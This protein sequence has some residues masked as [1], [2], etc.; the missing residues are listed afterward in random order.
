MLQQ[1]SRHRVFAA[2]L[3]SLGWLGASV[4]MFAL[5]AKR[6]AANVV[7]IA[8]VI[9]GV[10]FVYAGAWWLARR[11]RPQWTAS[12]A[13]ETA[14]PAKLARPWGLLLT[15]LVGVYAF[16]VTKHFSM[17]GYVPIVE[18]LSGTSEFDVS[19]VRQGGYFD[20]PGF[21]RYASDYSAKALGPA[22]L[23]VTYYFRSRLFWVVL[24]IGVF[25]ST[26]LFARILPIMLLAPLLLLM[27][28][29][30]R[31]LPA[32]AVVGLLCFQLAFATAVASP[33][34][35]EALKLPE[36]GDSANQIGETAPYVSP[37]SIKIPEHLKPPLKRPD[38]DWRRTSIVYSL[39]DRMLLVP[40]QVIDQWFQFY[41]EPEQRERG[42]GYRVVAPV[43][44]CTYVPI[45]SKLYAVFY[46][47]NVAQGMRGS[48]NAASFMTEFAN[49]GPAGFL[50]SALM[51]GLLFAA[52]SLIYRDHP[53]ALPMNLP[54]ILIAMET[55]LLTAVNS[56][57]GWLV[58]TAIFVIFFRLSAR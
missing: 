52:V 2:Y 21:M 25:Y 9:A 24:A 48:L 55:S 4:L 57:S 33:V 18:A 53:L 15:L 35:R 36:I 16:I 51:G 27:V 42:C 10:I 54:L 17:T 8:S 28:T 14:G 6:G 46:Q 56:G 5:D 50:L 19:I 43:L 44:G 26:G 40:G 13:S 12:S 45:P 47:D 38:E 1:L 3:L 39:Y 30:R 20:L 58:M 37:G 29:Q 11:V 41:D 49:F 23:L 31:W 7:F 22:L 34:I 32:A